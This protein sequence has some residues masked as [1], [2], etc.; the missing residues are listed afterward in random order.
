M[1]HIKKLVTALFL[2]VLCHFSASFGL[3]QNPASSTQ[4]NLSDIKGKQQLI[5]VEVTNETVKRQIE[6]LFR[7]GNRFQVVQNRKDAQLIYSAGI[8]EVESRPR[9]GTVERAAVPLLPSGERAG[10]IKQNNEAQFRETQYESQRKTRAFVYYQEPSGT[11][12]RVWSEET[13]RITKSNEPGGNLDSF[14][15][16]G[17]ELPLAKRFAKAVK[18]LK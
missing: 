14:R 7:E 16:F 2:V 5:F 17:D 13:V 8:V 15:N 1:T 12:V 4:R 6:E 18:S 3:S 9:F 10:V 11:R